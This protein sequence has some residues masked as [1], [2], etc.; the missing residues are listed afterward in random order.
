MDITD[1]GRLRIDL[2]ESPD[3]ATAAPGYGR[4]MAA[5]LR[6]APVLAAGGVIVVLALVAGPAVGAGPPAAVT[7]GKPPSKAEFVDRLARLCDDRHRAVTS[8]RVPFN[9]PRDYAARGSDLIR[10][11]RN[12]DRAQ[13]ALARPAEHRQ[14]DAAE[15]R[16]HRYKRRLPPLVDA[17]RRHLRRAWLLMYEAQAYLN[18]A[19]DIIQAYGGRRFCDL[20]P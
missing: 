14:I 8:L 3:D 13:H 18:D 17:S 7:A 2:R 15:A 5:A 20:G 6:R 10:I 19:S 4:A 1:P 12:F 9:S 11:E 16:Y